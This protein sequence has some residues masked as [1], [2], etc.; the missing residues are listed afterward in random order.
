MLGERPLL[1]AALPELLHDDPNS[2]TAP[3]P[4][5]AERPPPGQT[6][7]SACLDGAANNP[8]TSLP[9]CPAGKTAGP[10]RKPPSNPFP[11]TRT[12]KPS[13]HRRPL[14]TAYPLGPAQVARSG[15]A[16]LCPAMAPPQESVPLPPAYT[17][18]TG[19]ALTAAWLAGS[20]LAPPA[21]PILA[22]HRVLHH[23]H[24]R[25]QTRHQSGA[26]CRPH[27]PAADLHWQRENPRLAAAQ[28]CNPPRRIRLH[29]HNPPQP[30]RPATARQRTSR[31][32]GPGFWRARPP[33]PLPRAPS[34]IQ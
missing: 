24:S 14:T 19:Q 6:L 33:H 16:A 3:P 27:A 10:R 15:L 4:S 20:P 18:L 34:G 11:S 7:R 13:R 31:L 25:R 29:P 32:S 30:R 21:P 9:A 2:S 23:R 12:R 8:H 5:P 22:G 17:V 1:R 26:V 28:H